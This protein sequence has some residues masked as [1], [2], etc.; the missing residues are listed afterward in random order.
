[1]RPFDPYCKRYPDMIPEYVEAAAYDEV[2]PDEYVRTEEGTYNRENGHFACTEC[3]V[4]LGM[5]TAPW[6]WYA[7]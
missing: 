1:M 3:Y 6:G 2:T 5:P 4:N 7:P